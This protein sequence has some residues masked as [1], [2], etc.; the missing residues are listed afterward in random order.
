M[1]KQV[2]PS[3]LS[4]EG[5]I[6][7]ADY[8]YITTPSAWAELNDYMQFWREISVPTIVEAVRYYM[9]ATEGGEDA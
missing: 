4:E 8:D 5:I 1:L 3:P 9:E 6:A 2:I 7:C